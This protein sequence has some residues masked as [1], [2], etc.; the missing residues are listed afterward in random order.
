MKL[1]EITRRKNDV[2]LIHYACSNLRLNPVS[3]S[4]ISVF[5][6]G[7]NRTITF[8][9]CNWGNERALMDEF[10]RYVAS[11]PNSIFLGWNIKGVA[12]GPEMLDRRLKELTG[13]SLDYVKDNWLDFDDF[14]E[15]RYGPKYISDPKFRSLCVLNDFSLHDFRSGQDEVELFEKGD[16]RAI[17]L[18]VN[19]KVILLNDIFQ[20]MISN[21]L[22]TERPDLV[23]IVHGHDEESRIQL[24][25]FLTDE[26]G[27]PAIVLLEQ[28]DEGN[29][30]VEKLEKYANKATLAIILLTPDDKTIS[31]SA[32]PEEKR[33]ARQN[34]ILEMGYFFGRLGRRQV[35]LLYKESVEIPSDIYG[36][37]YKK[38]QNISD[39]KLELLKEIKTRLTKPE[40]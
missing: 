28:P 32:P 9:L 5:E 4:C 23:F 27:L 30:I 34:V 8:S 25:A 38:F 13:K 24:K 40:T 12:Y 7:R 35:I 2:I 14:L 33:R 17:E 6:S 15:Q 18:S 37:L 36:I 1:D 29:T 26:V 22:K 31:D 21:K 3:I 19:R 10:R 39:I 20:A 16:F 11:R